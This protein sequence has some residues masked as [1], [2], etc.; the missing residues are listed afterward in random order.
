LALGE[1][2]R[3]NQTNSLNKWVQWVYGTKYYYFENGKLVF[4]N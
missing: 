4:F 1:P 3:I 2:E